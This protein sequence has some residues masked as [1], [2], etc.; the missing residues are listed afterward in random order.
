VQLGEPTT[1][2]KKCDKNSR[3]YCVQKVIRMGTVMRKVRKKV[4]QSLCRSGQALREVEFP[5]FS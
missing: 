1:N 4:K 5:R 2:L 3:H